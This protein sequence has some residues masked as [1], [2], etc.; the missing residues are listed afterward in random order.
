MRRVQPDSRPRRAVPIGLALVAALPLGVATWAS[1]CS[2]AN[3]HAPTAE[4]VLV[5]AVDYLW[6]QQ[7][8][9]GGWHS[10]T[11][12]LL[13]G[14]EAW[15]PFVS[16]YLLQVPDSIRTKPA[17]AGARAVSFVRDHVNREGIVGLSDPTVLEYP[18]YSTSYALRV[19]LRWGE[20]ADGGLAD[21]MA[22]YLRNQQFV[23][24]RGIDSLHRGY[25]S[26]GFGETMLPYGEVGHLDLSHTR[27]V[28]E[29]LGEHDAA[30]GEH[31]IKARTLLRMLQRHPAERRLQPGAETAD[32]RAPYDG[33][34]YASTTVLGTNKGGLEVGPL[35]NA[36]Y[37]S[38]ATTTC[39][40]V[41]ALVA[42]GLATDDERIRSGLEWLRRNSDLT[43]VQGIPEDDA[44]GWDHALFYY[45]LLVRSEVYAVLGGPEGWREATV[46]LL[47]NRQRA[48]GSFSNPLGAPNKEDDPILATAMAVG[49]LL[50]VLQSG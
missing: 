27:R 20:K 17:G 2:G 7:Q 14:G 18:N 43:R 25:G 34:F 10:A 42:A 30:L 6:E 38:Y 45:H 9:D 41:L 28:L 23:E 19:L 47:A 39:D 8:S 22:A 46:A 40:G 5:Q 15:S 49:T 37:R 32:P 44:D 26:W 4:S 11:H 50:N 21:T 3:R 24:R 48:D 13:R 33:G 1:G 16:F 29:A 31:F 35:G 36:Y 12:G